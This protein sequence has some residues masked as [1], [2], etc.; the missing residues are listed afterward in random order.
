MPAE[1][2]LT[3][4][5]LR[6]RDREAALRFYRDVFGLQVEAEDNILYF[7]PEGGVFTL[8]LEVDPEAHRRPPRSVGL[9]HFALLPRPDPPATTPGH[10]PGAHASQRERPRERGNILRRRAGP[11]RDAA[12]LSGRALSRG[13]GLPPSPRPEHLGI[14]PSRSARLD[15]PAALWLA[16]PRRRAPCAGTA[17]DGARRVLP[18]DQRRPNRHRPPRDCR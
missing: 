7:R 4:L 15:G 3:G 6:V 16:H 17:P 9:Y 12:Q 18:K 2:G 1:A 8:T 5:A 10:D 14:A 13:R 11:E